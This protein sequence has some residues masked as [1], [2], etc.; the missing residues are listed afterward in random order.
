MAD[1]YNLPEQ[2]GVLHGDGG[3][4]GQ[5]LQAFGVLGR[6]SAGRIAIQ[7]EQPQ[8]TIVQANRYHEI[9]PDPGCIGEHHPAWFLMRVGN[10]QGLPGLYDLDIHR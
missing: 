9:R 5:G 2:P 7:P 4:V 10:D 3:R 6:E 1:R 8:D